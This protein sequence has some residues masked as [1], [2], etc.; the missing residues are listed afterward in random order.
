MINVDPVVPFQSAL[1][2]NAN[3]VEA[4]SKEIEAEVNITPNSEGLTLR[5]TGSL[6]SKKKIRNSKYP[7]KDRRSTSFPTAGTSPHTDIY[8]LK[9]I[10]RLQKEKPEVVD[11]KFLVDTMQYTDDS[12]VPTQPTSDPIAIHNAMNF[13]TGCVLFKDTEKDCKEIGKSPTLSSNFLRAPAVPSTF[14]KAV[15]ALDDEPVNRESH[16]QTSSSDLEDDGENSEED[17]SNSIFKSIGKHQ[18]GLFKPMTPRQDFTQKTRVDSEM[19]KVRLKYFTQKYNDR[20]TMSKEDWEK[21]YTSRRHGVQ[22]PEQLV[23]WR[24]RARVLDNEESCCICRKVIED[25]KIVALDCRPN[26]QHIGC[27]SCMFQALDKDDRCPVCRK[28]VK[29][30]IEV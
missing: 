5:V 29:F 13:R 19:T 27:L 12:F 30:S 16:S 28:P 10:R 23:S 17:S 11:Q 3:P 22:D 8:A 7:A 26:I 25:K 15:L 24:T 4:Y 1:E 6:D 14:D 2:A 21:K 18:D 20:S 9:L